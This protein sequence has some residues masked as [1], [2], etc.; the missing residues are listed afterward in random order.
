M[1]EELRVIGKGLDKIATTEDESET[2]RILIEDIVLAFLKSGRSTKSPRGERALS[3]IKPYITEETSLKP[4]DIPIFDY[5]SG[6]RLVYDA[7]LSIADEFDIYHL[8]ASEKEKGELSSR[9]E[10][11]KKPFSYISTPFNIA[12]S[13][14]YY[15]NLR[16]QTN[17]VAKNV[18]GISEVESL[19]YRTFLHKRARGKISTKK[20]KIDFPIGVVP[21]TISSVASKKKVSFGTLY[22]YVV[23]HEYIHRL[24]DQL[25]IKQIQKD[26]VKK[27]FA[28][29]SP[30]SVDEEIEATMITLE[31]YA[32]FFSDRASRKFQG[33]E[34]N[35][36][37]SLSNSLRNRLTGQQKSIE[38]YLKGREFIASLYDIGGVAL[39]NKSLVHPPKSFQEIQNPESYVGRIS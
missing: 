8:M 17:A 2:A 26:L 20:G 29:Q 24:Q 5:S 7:F 37:Y 30:K 39:A 19:F 6:K 31:G 34:Y 36:S 1:F 23:G 35:R 28:S 15:L 38:R 13:L 25:P 18:M 32:E 21:E 16:Y 11:T 27:S 3:K 22:T 4:L 12:K 9:A 33:F 10:G 14:W